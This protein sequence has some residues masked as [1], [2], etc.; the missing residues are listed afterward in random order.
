MWFHILHLN[1]SHYVIN[2]FEFILSTYYVFIDRFSVIYWSTYY[3][4]VTF[5]NFKKLLF[6]LILPDVLYLCTVPSVPIKS[7]NVNHS[8]ACF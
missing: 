5:V 4:Q 6:S 3:S 2:I 8:Y 7:K 1:L